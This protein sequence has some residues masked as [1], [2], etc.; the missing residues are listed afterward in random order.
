M[1][2]LTFKFDT[3][4]NDNEDWISKG[5]VVQVADIW[6]H[7]EGST[8]VIITEAIT[9]QGKHITFDYPVIESFMNCSFD[10][11]S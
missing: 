10:E 4:L 1:E 2:T 11:L 8:P 5:T 6:K 9:Y 7:H 3:Q